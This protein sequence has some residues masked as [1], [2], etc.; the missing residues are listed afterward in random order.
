MFEGWEWVEHHTSGATIA[1]TGNNIPYRLLGPD[2]DNRVYYVNV[3]RHFDWRY[4]D[5]VR[6]ERRRADYRPPDAPNPPYYRE[7]GYREAWVD[8]LTRARVDFVFISRLSLEITDVWKNAAGFPVEED[9]A[10]ADPRMFGVV[11]ENP[12]VRIYSIRR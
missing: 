7:H 12:E 1:Y 4:H 8:N 10:H 5:Y 6:A 3:D 9:W 2:F 11:F